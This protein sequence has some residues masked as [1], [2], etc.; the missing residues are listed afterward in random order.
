MKA[1]YGA[2]SATLCT[3]LYAQY[4]YHKILRTI[5]S[6]VNTILHPLRLLQGTQVI[7]ERSPHLRREPAY[8]D[9]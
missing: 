5:T 8:S 2:L 4:V 6:T 7:S 9:E 3:L 1:V